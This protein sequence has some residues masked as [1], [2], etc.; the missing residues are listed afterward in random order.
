VS[1][2]CICE[3]KV[4]LSQPATD[5]YI[6]PN[7]PKNKLDNATASYIHP[8]KADPE[9]H[10]L[11][12]YD[13]SFWGGA[14]HG[15]CLCENAVYWKHYT[16]DEA[17]FLNY[18]SIWRVDANGAKLEINGKLLVDMAFGKESTLTF[19]SGLLLRLRE[20][21]LRHIHAEPQ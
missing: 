8:F 17:Q 5:T 18:C 1:F 7:I 9:P 21:H 14:M 19:L 15:L 4:R 11:L 13:P 2:C 3:A 16:E 20:L 10:V 12:L 6:W